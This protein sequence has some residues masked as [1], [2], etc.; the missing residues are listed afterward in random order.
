MVVSVS[1]VHPHDHVA[2][3][4]LR[5]IAAAQHQERKSDCIT[6]AR[7]KIQIQS[8]VSTECVLLLHR[9]KVKRS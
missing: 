9:R 7:K 1:A 4:E 8:T 2:D 5:F 3:W 6:P